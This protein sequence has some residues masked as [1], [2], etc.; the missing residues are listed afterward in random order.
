MPS[1]AYDLWQ[2]ERLPALDELESAHQSVGG[3]GRGRR[4]ATQQINQA[5]AVLLSSQFQGYC[6][7]LH[8]ECVDHIIQTSVALALQRTIQVQLVQGRRLDHGNPNPGNI[9]ADFG[10]FGVQFWDHVRRFDW[11]TDARRVGL[12]ELNSWRNAIAHQDFTS[13]RLGG[14]RRL[15]LAR[16]RRW[17]RCCE[18][19]VPSFE[20]ALYAYLS[21][22]TGTAPW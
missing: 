2:R 7:D 8:T 14:Q 16:V 3:V 9:G 1:A 19:L 13:S 12:E 6:R 5:Y 17:R 4:Y 11:R 15:I 10:R 18:G 20:A 21:Q 22:V